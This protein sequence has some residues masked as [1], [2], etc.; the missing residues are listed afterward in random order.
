MAVKS[1]MYQIYELRDEIKK[2]INN[3]NTVEQS[4]KRLVALI[5]EAKGE[6]EFK[7]FIKDIQANWKEYA[8]TRLELNSRLEKIERIIKLHEAQDDHSPVVNEVVT[9]LLESFGLAKAEPKK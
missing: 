2:A 4:E 6:L 8:A 7:D 3:S 5:I 1:R 9:L